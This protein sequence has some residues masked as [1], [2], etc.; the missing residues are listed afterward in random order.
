MQRHLP[1]ESSLLHDE[2]LIARYARILKEEGMSA[3]AWAVYR[4]FAGHIAH[5]LVIPRHTTLTPR[6]LSRSCMQKPFCEAFSSFVNTYEQIRY[7]GQ[8]S[9]AIQEEFEGRMDATRAE[10][11]DGL[12]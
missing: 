5:T 7:G 4:Q 9:A 10:M 3:A 2:P 6:E 11:E 1:G 12:S 8:R